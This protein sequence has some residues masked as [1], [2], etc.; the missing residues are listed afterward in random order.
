M[1]DGLEVRQVAL[2]D[3]YQSRLNNLLEPIQDRR[4]RSLVWVLGFY[5]EAP[6][7]SL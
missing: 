7:M 4:I 5:H 1:G 2:A 3:H 6:T